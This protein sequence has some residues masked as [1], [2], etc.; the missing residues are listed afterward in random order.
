MAKT[1]KKLARLTPHED[2]CWVIAFCYYV[3][4]GCSDLKADKLG[5]LDMCEEFP[6]LREYEG[7]LP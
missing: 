5:W 7:C 4:D 2:R 1:R 3:D 6:R